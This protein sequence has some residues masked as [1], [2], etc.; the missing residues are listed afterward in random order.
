MPGEDEAFAAGKRL[1]GA[2]TRSTTL[3]PVVDRKSERSKA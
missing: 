3:K 1:D 2:T